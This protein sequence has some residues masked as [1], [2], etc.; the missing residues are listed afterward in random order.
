MNLQQLSAALGLSKTTVSRA[1][2]GYPDVSSAT[3]ERVREAAERFGYRP[4]AI[5]RRLASGRVEAVGVILPTGAGHFDDPFFLELMT[6][7]GER[8]AE[9]E[10]DLLATTAAPGEVEMRALAR[11]VE[12]RRVDAVVV[13]RTHVHDERVAYL[14]DRGFPFVCHGRV[15]EDRPYAYLDTDGAGAFAAAVARLAGLGHTRIGFIGAPDHLYHAVD[16][17]RGFRSGMKAAGL[18]VQESWVRQGA[19]GEAQAISLVAP[20]LDDP[21]RPTAI[22]CT[23]DRLA[24]GVMRAARERG[25]RIPRDLSVIGFDDLPL[26]RVS[27]PPLTTFDQSVGKAGRRLVEML[28]ALLA[29]EPAERLREIW[30]VE[31][32][33]RGSDGP[34]PGTLRTQHLTPAD[35]AQP[36]EQAPSHQG[37]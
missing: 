28:L 10:L 22:L 19:S 26:G 16:R 32:A 17:L 23:T 8:L 3:R 37:G 14:L 21:D 2:A 9:A 11:L 15:E 25:I 13:A 35:R 27:D 24:I 12:H 6:A 4:S 29:G 20:L 34:A 1:L 18:A 5:A 31:L 30:P 7:M 33:I 36:A